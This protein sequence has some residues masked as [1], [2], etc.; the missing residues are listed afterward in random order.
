MGLSG[1]SS[2]CGAAMPRPLTPIIVAPP[3]AM[4]V[5]LRNFLRSR[6]LLLRVIRFSSLQG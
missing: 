2:A 5:I 4:A 1:S 3:A 6:S